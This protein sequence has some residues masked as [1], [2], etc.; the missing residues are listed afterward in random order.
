MSDTNHTWEEKTV[1][2]IVPFPKDLEDTVND[3]CGKALDDAKNKLHPL[4]RQVEL[5]RL[6]ERVEFLEAFKISLEKRIARKFAAWLPGVQAV[7]KYDETRLEHLQDWDGSIHLLVKVPRLSNTVKMLARRLDQNLIRYFKHKAWERFCSR[8][9]ILEV[10]Q[11]TPQE[12]RHGIG[13]GAMF[14]AVYTVPVKVWPQDRR[15]S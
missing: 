6:E 4:L 14:H 5:S 10:H 7:F 9:S 15:A 12:L 11:V 1:Q 8:P 3:L 2:R 13:Y